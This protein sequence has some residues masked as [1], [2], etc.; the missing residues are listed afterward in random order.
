MLVQY[1]VG[2]LADPFVY[3]QC[4]QY[5]MIDAN[6]NGHGHLAITGRDTIQAASNSRMPPEKC[7]LLNHSEQRKLDIAESSGYIQVDFFYVLK[8]CN[9]PLTGLICIL[10]LPML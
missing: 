4:A 7:P 3:A 2:Q 9:C 8:F 5:R 6:P 10:P 1:S